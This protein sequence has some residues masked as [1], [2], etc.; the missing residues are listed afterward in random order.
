MCIIA[1][2]LT[3]TNLNWDFSTLLR[4]L[5]LWTKEYFQCYNIS[6]DEEKDDVV[7]DIFYAKMKDVY[8]KCRCPSRQNFPRRRVSD[9]DQLILHAAFTSNFR[10]RA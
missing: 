5:R 3:S 9:V 8:D 7:K 10:S 2:M 1:S 4:G 6:L